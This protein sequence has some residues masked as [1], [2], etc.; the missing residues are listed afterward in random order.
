MGTLNLQAE[1]YYRNRIKRALEMRG[2]RM[3]MEDEW[4]IHGPHQD[5]NYVVYVGHAYFDKWQP[6]QHILDKN[7]PEW[8]W[9]AI[10]PRSVYEIEEESEW[11]TKGSEQRIFVFEN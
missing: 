9:V 11:Y 3:D 7:R 6:S 2:L 5:M 4:E 10:Y 1:P 8:M